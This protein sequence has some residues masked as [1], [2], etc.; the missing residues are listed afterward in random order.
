MRRIVPLAVLLACAPT[1]T[2]SPEPVATPPQQ[3]A[4]P[5]APPAP[6]DRDHDGVADASDRCPDEPEDR[7]GFE[8]LDGCVDRDNDGDTIPDA[9]EFIGGR[10]TNCDYQITATGDD[11][12][13]RMLPEDFDGIEDD[14]GC[15]EFSGWHDCQP[16][17]TSVVHFET[18]GQLTA[19]A[20]QILDGIAA[21]LQTDPRITLGVAAHADN[22][23]SDA[24]AKALTTAVAQHVTDEL[25]RRGVARERLEPRAMGKQTPRDDNRTAKGRAN[26]RRIEFI[27]VECERLQSPP[28]LPPKPQACR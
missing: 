28:P 9:H 3:P 13:C 6:A 15:P 25:V 24:A 17:L 10:W 23:H 7:D 20:G 5:P 22:N 26:N 16:T 18:K 14:D 19:T 12:D 27:V 1:P 8:D 11:R 2:R 21:L 4:I